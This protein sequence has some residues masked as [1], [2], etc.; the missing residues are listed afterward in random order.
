MTPSLLPLRPSNSS[1]SRVGQALTLDI[2]DGPVDGR[3]VRLLGAA[4]GIVQRG[5]RGLHANCGPMRNLN[6]TYHAGENPSRTSLDGN[7][8]QCTDAGGHGHRQRTPKRHARGCGHEIRSPG[9]RPNGT[10]QGEK[11]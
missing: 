4:A 3:G 6:R 1:P 5:E 8:R 9:F 10:E 11:A 2:Y 7:P